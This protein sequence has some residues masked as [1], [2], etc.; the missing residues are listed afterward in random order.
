MTKTS[1]KL[2]A[3]LLALVLFA[4]TEGE[5]TRSGVEESIGMMINPDHAAKCD[6]NKD[7]VGKCVQCTKVCR[8]FM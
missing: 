1:F 4:H 8:C 3:F 2:V 6:L 7:C 5:A